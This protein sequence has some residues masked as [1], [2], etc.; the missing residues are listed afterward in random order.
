[1]FVVN[2][3]KTVTIQKIALYVDGQAKELG[4]YFIGNF[5]KR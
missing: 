1:M 2:T 5:Y 4:R 3:D